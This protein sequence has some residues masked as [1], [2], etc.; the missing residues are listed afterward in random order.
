MEK[1]FGRMPMG[2][3]V[4]VVFAYAKFARHRYRKTPETVAGI[5]EFLARRRTESDRDAAR[6]RV[7]LVAQNDPS[8][9]VKGLQVPCYAL[10]GFLDGLVAWPRVRRWLKKNCPTFR[11][12]VVVRGADHAVLNTGVL[13]SAQW[14]LKWMGAPAAPALPVD[15]SPERAKIKA[16]S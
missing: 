13:E 12:F 8:A 15:D 1:I 5:D 3:F 4:R 6:H 9:T 16:T 2:F 10:S 11:E 14:V 7:H